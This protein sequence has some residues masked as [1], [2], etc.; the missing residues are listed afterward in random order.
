[1]PTI[2]SRDSQDDV[3]IGVDEL[4]ALDAG[5]VLDC[6]ALLSFNQLCT[7]HKHITHAHR[8]CKRRAH[9]P[10]SLS[11]QSLRVYGRVINFP[12]LIRC[13]SESSCFAKDFAKCFFSVSAFI[14]LSHLGHRVS[15]SSDFGRPLRPVQCFDWATC[16]RTAGPLTDCFP[17]ARGMR[18]YSMQ[19]FV[20]KP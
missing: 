15:P 13:R 20:V 19:R 4:L 14:V 17:M 1:M 10:E 6:S 11:T 5:H 18:R 12:L 8:T 9:I 2:G 7:S 3:T 16:S